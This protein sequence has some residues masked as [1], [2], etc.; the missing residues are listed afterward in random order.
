MRPFLF[1]ITLGLTSALAISAANGASLVDRYYAALHMDEVFEILRDEGIVAGQ[2]MTEDGQISASPAWTARL[3]RIYAID[4]MDAVF[5]HALEKTAGF[6]TSEEAIAF[7]ETELGQKLSRLELDARV[8]LAAEG[9]EAQMLDRV[10]EMRKENPDRIAL[11]QEF[12]DVND[13]VESNVSGA[14][15]ANLSF[16]QG[17]ASNPAF[18]AGMD[19]DFMLTTVWAQEGEI[20][21]NMKDWTISFSALAYGVLSRQDMQDYID[22]SQT[23]SGQKLNA[24]L[25]AGFDK[26]FEVQSFELG[27]ATAEFAAGD[28]T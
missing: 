24:A 19:E 28:D 3:G 16:Y 5:R 7:F 8:A 6:E 4:K 14:L 17:M 2:G 12:I 13:L 10:E 1:S 18:G 25:F 22:I 9:M 21:D 20:R 11:Y 27:R 26:V 23:A 15:N